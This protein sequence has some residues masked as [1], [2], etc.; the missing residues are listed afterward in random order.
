MLFTLIFAAIIIFVVS[1]EFYTLRTG[2]PTSASFLSAQRKIIDILKTHT[3]HHPSPTILDLGSGNG[4]L[5]WRVAKALP[6]A[7]VIGIEISFFPWF[8]SVLR[9]KLTGTK[10]LSYRRVDFWT[11]DCSQTD[12]VLTYLTEN[13]ISRVS[14]KLHAELKPQAL[15]VAN[16]VWLMGSWQPFETYDNPMF[17]RFNSQIYVYRQT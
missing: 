7:K 15:V 17:G 14:E 13:I 4:Q 2:V 8:N 9:Q 6:H 11:Y 16:D 1:C 12:V 10:N 3:A 5:A